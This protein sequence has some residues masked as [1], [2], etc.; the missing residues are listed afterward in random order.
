MVQVNPISDEYFH[1]NYKTNYKINMDLKNIS[2]INVI[3][4][5]YYLKNK[6]IY[7]WS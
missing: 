6:I 4:L 5:A 7:I 1:L 2:I 3:H